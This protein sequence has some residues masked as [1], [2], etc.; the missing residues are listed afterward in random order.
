MVRADGRIA[1]A[2]CHAIARAGER[3]RA[4]PAPLLAPPGLPTPTALNLIGTNM[5]KSRDDGDRTFKIK[6]AVYKTAAAVGKFPQ[7][8]GRCHR[9]P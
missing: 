7:L 5:S 8:A 1:A 6:K 2:S 4:T 3:A 9:T